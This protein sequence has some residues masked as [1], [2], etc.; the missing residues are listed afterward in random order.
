MQ[1]DKFYRSQSAY[2]GKA[3]LTCLESQVTFLS[4]R[5]SP[6]THHLYILILYFQPRC[7]LARMPSIAVV[8]RSAEERAPPASSVLHLS[9]HHHSNSLGGLKEGG[10]LLGIK[11]VPLKGIH[12][13]RSTAGLPAFILASKDPCYI[14]HVPA[15]TWHFRKLLVSIN[16]A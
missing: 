3:D 2:L 5:S 16:L 12:N 4:I 15:T 14:N 10:E 8:S 11:A 7:Q 1:S 13:S 9:I 6:H